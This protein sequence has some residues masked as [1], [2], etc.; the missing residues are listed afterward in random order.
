MTS[1]ATAR[2]AG[3][4]FLLYIALGLTAMAL[5]SGA[6]SGMAAHMAHLADH[7]PAERLANVLTLLCSF[8]ALILGVTLYGLTRAVD[9]ELALLGMAFRITEGVLGGA[10]LMPAFGMLWLATASGANAPDPAAAHVL[11]GFVQ[12][13]SGT[14]PLV[15]A[16]FF[17]AGSTL[18]CWL[19]LRGRMIPL[20]LAWLGVAASALLLVGLPLQLGGVAGGMAATLMWLPMLVFELWLAVWLIIKGVAAP[21]VVE[22]DR[23]AFAPA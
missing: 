1:T 19:L 9:R 5:T 10:S 4:T 11:A 23:K 21:A 16:T 14:S 22:A 20:W 17:A 12:Q 2:V 13:M 6:A 8:C 3:A 18:F 7:E 15:C